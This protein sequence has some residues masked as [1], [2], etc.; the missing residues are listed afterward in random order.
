MGEPSNKI[1]IDSERRDYVKKCIENSEA[2]IMMEYLSPLISSKCQNEADI[3]EMKKLK[4][5]QDETN[6]SKKRS[7]RGSFK[8]SERSQN[9]NYIAKMD[10]LDRLCSNI[11]IFGECKLDH[12]TCKK[13]HNIEE[14][15]KIKR[16]EAETKI[17][18]HEESL[19]IQKSCP[20]FE[21]YGICHLGLNCKFG[22]SHF[23]ESIMANV[24]SK[25]EKV[26]PEHLEEFFNSF[27][28]NTIDIQLRTGL[29]QR[30]MNFPKTKD[31]FDNYTLSTNKTLKDCEKK[32]PK[33]N[34]KKAQN[35]D[36]PLLVGLKNT[37]NSTPLDEKGP[38]TITET[39]NQ[40]NI[41]IP[42]ELKLST[43]DM[44][45]GISIH[46]KEKCKHK[47]FRNKLILAPLTTVGN[48]PF[49]RLCLK[50]GADV[51]VS[52]MVLCNEILSGKA[53]ELA[54]LKKSP[55]EKH[56]GIQLAGGNKSTIIK[57]GEFINEHCEFDFIDINA[58][59]PLK[60]LHDKGAGSILVD[61]VS[62]L[63]TMVKGL[64]KVMDGKLVTVKVRMSHGGSPI[65]KNL[66]EKDYFENFEN[67]PVIYHNMKTHKIL[68][69]L[70]DS[71]IDA[72]TIHGRTSFQRY[73]KEADWSYIKYCS[74]LN[75]KLYSNKVANN[76]QSSNHSL[77]C[78]SIIGCG[79][80]I[81]FQDYQQHIQNDLVD[82]VM[83]GRGALLKPW[84][85]TEIKENR[86]WDIS[87]SERFDI[88]KQ[89]V[90]LGLEHWGTDKRGIALT[91]RFLLEFLSFFHRYIPI[92]IL[93]QPIHT[94]NFNWRTPKYIGRND[95]ETM[96]ASSNSSDW[97]KISEMILGKVPS[98]FVFIPKHKAN[99]S[100]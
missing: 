100:H 65:N 35:F 86:N 50:F 48:L 61:R 62:E 63:E 31:F 10:D 25:G 83:I 87:A 26:T 24:N 88:I 41:E 23:N 17:R 46:E 70:C 96:L 29:R 72:L 16:E 14:F 91:R 19:L 8:A 39:N 84:I 55:E 92:G 89:Y 99:S 1:P 74:V 78:P 34:C 60:S 13:S 97:I 94:Q 57:T 66:S 82:S 53:S 51:T 71:G 2:P 80:I 45:I 69:I 73:T 52:E 12:N 79:D 15:L 93:E 98:D 49:R 95:L 5:D 81:N 76:I 32:N 21:N 18:D 9:L 90:N 75:S 38:N 64:K 33:P 77:F 67:W 85:F 7:I 54:L 68:N 20:L 58:A 28:K 11:A 27:E 59:C 22:L 40:P 3:S 56:F 36:N 37:D 6:S 42:Q 30:T 43:E 44:L 47:I 4:E